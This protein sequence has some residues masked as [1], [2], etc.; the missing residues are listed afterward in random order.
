[1]FIPNF[2]TKKN[3][4]SSIESQFIIEP[5]PLSLGHSLGNALRRT[6]LSSIEGAAITQVKIE[7]APHLFSTLKGVK[8]SVLEIVLNLKQL[9]FKFEG[10]GPFMIKVDAKGK[11][12]IFGKDV[13]GEV[14]IVNKDFYLG[15]ITDSKGKLDIEAMVEV[16][17][18][19]L[20]AKEQKKKEYGFI[21][22][23]AFFSPVKKANFKIEESRLGGKT[24]Y[25]RLIIQLTTDGSIQPEVVLRKAGSFLSDFFGRIL[26]GSDNPPTKIEKTTEEKHQEALQSKFSEII[27]DELNLPSRII[28]ALLREKIETVANLISAGK[29]KLSMMKGVGKKSIELIEEELKKMGI[30]LS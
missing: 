23:D 14:E 18:G 16:G 10:N 24:D 5:L 9:R 4:L 11:K 15:E 3:E 28:N 30:E 19:Y 22:V 27:I 1:M 8:E 6:L 29:E 26:S 7:D 20:Q 25:E 13:E 17:V 2:F 21:P 12:K